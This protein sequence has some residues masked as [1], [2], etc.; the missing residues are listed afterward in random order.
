MITGIGLG[1][2]VDLLV[3]VPLFIISIIFFTG[4][5]FNRK[6]IKHKLAACGVFITTFLIFGFWPL[7]ALGEGSATAHVIQLGLAD[8]FTQTLKI[9]ISPIYSFFPF[10]NDHYIW[11]NVYSFGYYYL[12]HHSA[13]YTY[14]PFTS[15]FH[16][17][18]NLYLWEYIKTF[19]ADMIMRCYAS[20]WQ[21]LQM[22]YTS[23]FVK[24]TYWRE[25][26]ELLRFLALFFPVVSLLMIRSF[27]LR[28]GLF[29]MFAI[30]YLCAYPALQFGLRHYFYLSFISVW[31][32]GFVC[33]QILSL[34][35]KASMN[36]L[37]LRV[38]FVNEEK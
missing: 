2:R 22:L 37:P 13:A 23:L 15:S 33:Q 29:V 36:V 3:Y 8:R 28:I 38:R 11:Y 31:F 25:H 12:G 27:S 5:G 30:M 19:P 6:N 35:F 32:V 14:S 20:I 18:S 24:Y 16:H 1:F 17:L 34:L 9:S 7:T 10:Y 4:H 26:L 21:V